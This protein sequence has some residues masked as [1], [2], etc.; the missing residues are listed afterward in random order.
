[1]KITNIDQVLEL[2]D[3]LNKVHEATNVNTTI[4]VDEL[5]EDDIRQLAKQEDATVFEPCDL[6]PYLF[7]EIKLLFVRSAVLGYF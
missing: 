4:T 2:A 7:S 5:I 6:V 1:M 3:V